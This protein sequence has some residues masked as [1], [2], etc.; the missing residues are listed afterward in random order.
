MSKVSCIGIDIGMSYSSVALY[1]HGKVQVIQTIPSCVAFAG[2]KRLFGIPARSQAP[3]NSANTVSNIKRLIG[4]Q[5]DDGLV[6]SEINKSSFK[7]FN[8]NNNPVIEVEFNG[9]KRIFTPQEI[10]A[11]ILWK[12]KDIAEAYLGYSV[13]NAVVAVPACYND[14]QRQAVLDAGTIA[15]L[16]IKR[17][18]NE[19][20]AAAV[21]FALN[22]KMVEEH[23]VLIFCFGGGF[24]E[25][26]IITI[27]DGLLVVEATAGDSHLGG[28]DFD[29]RMVAYF[30]EQFRRLFHRD[31]SNNHCALRRL[32]NACEKAKRILSSSPST[33]IDIN[34]L[35][36]DIPAEGMSPKAYDFYATITRDKFEELCLDLFEKAIGLVEQTVKTARMKEDDI[37]DIVLVGGCSRIPM[38]QKRLFEYFNG[39]EMNKTFSPDE[40]VACGAAIQAANVFDGKGNQIDLMVLDTSCFTADIEVAGG[41]FIP[42]TLNSTVPGK[43]TE[44]FTINADNELVLLSDSQKPLT[45]DKNHKALIKLYNG[46]GPLAKSANSSNF[47]CILELTDIPPGQTEIEVKCVSDMNGI[48][49]VSALEK[50]S[51]RNTDVNLIAERS[52]L[53]KNEIQQMIK[54]VAMLK[55]QDEIATSPKTIIIENTL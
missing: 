13:K 48:N 29:D 16:C 12:L 5:F 35:C 37:S 7:V 44:K 54:T 51:G 23:R 49:T 14:A 38:V 19:P 28:E 11:M 41:S 46:V 8:K 20:T 50:N 3:M 42:L 47:C 24:T 27:E 26:K 15:G 4:R 34:N 21:A 43:K 17:L 36:E 1:E 32:R 52:R 25:V 18:I 10:T 45:S 30:S 6:Q 31:I 55:Q 33:A 2:A 40:A 22:K 39:R 9:E 53:S